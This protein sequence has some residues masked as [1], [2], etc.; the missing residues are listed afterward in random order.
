MPVR[1]RGLNRLILLRR[2]RSESSLALIRCLPESWATADV[3]IC[4]GA[5]VEII[6]SAS[7][8]NGT[9]LPRRTAEKMLIAGRSVWN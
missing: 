7:G 2:G 5:T 6:R 4:V 8:L 9:I 3:A 1:S